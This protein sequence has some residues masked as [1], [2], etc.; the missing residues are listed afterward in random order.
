MVGAVAVPVLAALALYWEGLTLG[1][2]QAH[3]SHRS[4]HDRLVS[5]TGIATTTIT[6]M[7][8][9]MDMLNPEIRPGADKKLSEASP[10]PPPPP[11]P[12]PSFP[13]PPP[14]LLA[15]LPPPPPSYP[16]PSP[17]E[18]QHTAEIYV[19]MKN[20]LRHVESEVLKKEVTPCTVLRC[21]APQGGIL[22]KPL[23]DG[24]HFPLSGLSG[25]TTVGSRKGL[26][27]G[28]G[29]GALPGCS[30]QCDKVWSSSNCF[31]GDPSLMGVGGES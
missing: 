8:T 17:P 31:S 12:P 18:A 10:P 15:R 23:A 30:L 29:L 13:P 20:N 26:A 21:T 7:Q 19:Q 1:W 5:P 3:G 11:P 4:H 22:A 16:A 9:Y 28:L 2:V 27:R 24:F 14:P 25:C 6:D